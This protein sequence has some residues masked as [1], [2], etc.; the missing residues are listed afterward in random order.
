MGRPL[1]NVRAYVLDDALRPT[2]VGVAGELCLAGAQ[3]A[4]G[5]LHRPGLTAARFLADPFGAPG[6]RMY[7]TGDRAHWTATGIVEFLGRTDDQI[8]IRGFRIEPGEIE[9]ALLALSGIA[10]APVVA[11]AGDDGA[12]PAGRLPLPTARSASPD[13]TRV[14]YPAR[15]VPAR[16]HGPLH[17]RR[18]RPAAADPEREAGPSGPAR[19]RPRRGDTHRVRGPAHR[20]RKPRRPGQVWAEVLGVDRN[21]PYGA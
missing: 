20:R 3:L 12:H 13:R 14:A 15:P 5:Y 17:D 1:R 8:K 9:T 19:A 21:D 18:P 2:P 11:S 16:L 7:R 4:R 6:D 10:D